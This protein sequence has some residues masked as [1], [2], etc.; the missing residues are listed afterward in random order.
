MDGELD[1]IVRVLRGTEPPEPEGFEQRYSDR[2][3]EFAV[4]I[5]RA[6]GLAYGRVMMARELGTFAACWTK[7]ELTGLPPPV[8]TELWAEALT[9]ASKL[10]KKRKLKKPGAMFCRIWDSLL[11]KA[12][13]GS[14]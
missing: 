7:A 13:A 14:S 1:R 6:L 11:A 2:A 9:Q 10:R 12:G 4:T 8:A 5:Y 3:K